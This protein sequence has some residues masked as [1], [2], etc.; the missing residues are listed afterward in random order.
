MKHYAKQML[1]TPIQSLFII[2]LI[3][4]VT[5]MLVVG[6][7]L[8]VTSGRISRA[9]EDDFITIGTVAQKPDTVAEEKE[10]DAEKKDYRIYKRNRYNRY[11]TVEDLEFSEVDYVVGPEKRDYWGSYMPDYVQ[12]DDLVPYP[13]T[14]F[15]IVAEFSPLEDCTPNESVKIKITKIWGDADR[16]EGTVVWFCDHYNRYPKELKADKTYVAMISNIEWVHGARWE[17]SGNLDRHLEYGPQKVTN[18]L[19]T[20]E[21]E[22]I[23]DSC[24]MEAIYEVTEGFYE[25]EVGR[26]FVEISN[27]GAVYFDTQPV[28]G[29]NS[30]DLLQP[31]YEGSAWI[32]EGR[33]PTAEEYAQ[34]STVC[35]VPRIFAENNG[36]SLGDQVTTR[37]YYTCPADDVDQNFYIMGGGGYHFSFLGPDGKLLAPFE[38][39]AYTIVGIY[40]YTPAVQ[41]IGSDE[42]IVP[43]DSVQKKTENIVKYTA[44]SD[45]NTS[46]RIKNGTIPDY[47]EA[48]AKHGVDNLVFTF[49][50]RGYTALKEGIRNLKN[51]SAALL[52]MG[53]IAAV[54]LTLQISHIYITKQRKRLAVERLMGMTGRQCRRISLA[55]ILI[56]LMLGTVPGVAAGMA[57]AG[58]VDVAGQTDAGIKDAGQTEAGQEGEAGS[59]QTD[60]GQE[61]KV[62]GGRINTGEEFSRKYSNLGMASETNVVFCGQ[63]RT[64]T[65]VSCAMGAL[66]VL[67]GM[68]LS[69][70]RVRGLLKGEPLYLVEDESGKC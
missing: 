10:W 34:G 69:G 32:C 40:D 27:V 22:R 61:G 66:V 51:M 24:D 17:E 4:I 15:V 37:L 49:Y 5:V 64:D 62:A 47:L 67:L 2:L 54:I 46:F 44:M 25:T 29:T 11:A 21:G 9:Y 1:R 7:N 20:P 63:N 41:G 14:D 57:V 39:K 23:E 70:I 53:L 12:I 16:M 3:M 8:W 31:F 19:Y 28:V 52:A 26:R 36:L 56:L 60:A 30:T 58:Q 48:A 65:M 6:G 50:D 45:E 38:E 59:E 18:T 33:Y 68:G 43:L 55:G 13:Q 35:L 42:L